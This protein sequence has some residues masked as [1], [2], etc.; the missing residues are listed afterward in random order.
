MTSQSYG[1]DDLSVFRPAK[2]V[3]Y[4]FIGIAAVSALVVLAWLSYL[5]M[6]EPAAEAFSNTAP[7]MFSSF[8]LILTALLFRVYRIETYADHVRVVC[9]LRAR[10]IGFKDVNKITLKKGFRNGD[11][12]EV[13]DKNGRRLLAVSSSIDDQ[14]GLLWTIRMGARKY[15]AIFMCRDEFGVWGKPS[16]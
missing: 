5:L 1:S 7:W 14:D 12:I 16:N 8:W 6:T 4:T 9:L 2:P 3:I 15:G 13:Y 10:D 11:V